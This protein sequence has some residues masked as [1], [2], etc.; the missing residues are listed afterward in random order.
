MK[1]MHRGSTHR[2]KRG[3]TPQ[4][5]SET[6][7]PDR[8]LM[9][10]VDGS[11]GDV[12][13][14]TSHLATCRVPQSTRGHRRNTLG[15][16]DRAKVGPHERADTKRSR[17][18]TDVASMTSASRPAMSRQPKWS[19]RGRT[20][21]S[22]P[23]K[24]EPRESQWSATSSCSSSGVL[25]CIE[26]GSDTGLQLGERQFAK[27][28]ATTEQKETVR[29]ITGRQNGAQPA[30]ET[31]PRHSVA[32]GAIERKRHLWGRN[33]GVSDKRAPHGCT[34]DAHAVAPKANEGVTITDPIGQISGSGRQAGAALVPAGLE[35]GATS[36]GAHAGS[37]TVLTV[38]AS[39][40]G[41]ECAL[42]DDLFRTYRA[43]LRWMTRADDSTLQAS[44]TGPHRGL[45]RQGYGAICATPNARRSSPCQRASS[46]Q[47]GRH[48]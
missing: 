10:R 15:R 42:H 48:V 17:P 24:S 16:N 30:P 4:R 3:R 33:V 11:A 23:G 6:Q 19:Q 38:P 2:G 45:T 26:K 32:Q 7:E 14:S 28:R 1:K 21:A 5:Q 37:E 9:V 31:I 12:G 18:A 34:P 22:R 47:A 13:R 43:M 27:W 46:Q 36:T 40:V 20:N 25:S 35:H 41:L 29:Q 39:V 8:N 44:V